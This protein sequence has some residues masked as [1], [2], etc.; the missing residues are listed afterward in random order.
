MERNIH[1]GKHYL[2]FISDKKILCL[3]DGEHYP[4]VTKWTIEEI[5]KRGGKVVGLVFLGGTEKIEKSLNLEKEYGYRVYAGEIKDKIPF[6]I[7]NSAIKK[8][9]PEV[10]LDLTDEPIVD[11]H[12]RFEIASIVIKNDLP[13]VGSDFVFSPPTKSD[14]LE[15]PSISIIGTGKR[16]GKTSVGV[17]IS[18]LLKKKGFNP[19]SVCM[20]RG[21]PS[22]PVFINPAEMKVDADKLLEISDKGLHAASDYWENALLSQIP[23]VGCRRCG[24]GMAGNPFASNVLEGAE[25]A[26]E[27]SQDFVIMEGSGPT[28]PPTRT[29]R[30]I[31][32]VGAGQPLNNIIGFFGEYRISS[33]DLVVVTMCE[34]PIADDEKVNNIL[35]GIKNIDSD[36]EILLTVFRPEPLGDIKGKKVFVA[37]T[38]PKKVNQVIRKSLS[39]YGCDIKGI[40]NNLSNRSL[41]RKDLIENLDKCD[42]LL[43]EIKAA[44]ID[45]AASEARKN[46]VDIVFLHNQPVL[47][48]GTV[49]NFD[50][51]VISVCEKALEDWVNDKSS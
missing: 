3:V 51:A 47:V 18:R 44:S 38:A 7:I 26:N 28:I 4:P 23:T 33:S 11:Y 32:V 36:I 40:S 20:G 50:E 2:R 12:S 13:Y 29:N 25:M 49:E 8:E 16:V 39:D 24:G 43:T 17:T 9:S 30:R 5:E 45:V 42:M 22:D 35:N 46:G 21:G 27:S 34:E 48:G 14:V 31:V 19:V 37:T 6:D 1:P 10:V 15:K 41:L